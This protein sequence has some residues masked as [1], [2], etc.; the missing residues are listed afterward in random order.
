MAIGGVV[1]KI[2]LSHPEISFKFI[3]DGEVKFMTSGSGELREAIWAV[4]YTHLVPV[5]M[6]SM[7]SALQSC[8][9]TR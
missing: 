3:S 2:A 4:S 6:V 9:Q 8:M 5:S 1:E 7:Y